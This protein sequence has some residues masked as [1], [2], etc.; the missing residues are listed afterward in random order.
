MIS[1]IDNSSGFCN[2]IAVSWRLIS[3][4][5]WHL[6]LEWVSSSNN[7]S[8]QVSRQVFEEMHQTGAEYDCLE[9][10]PVFR[11]LQ[12]VAADHDY[13]YG[14]ALDD[15]MAISIHS[16]ASSA[17]WKDGWSGA[18]VEETAAPDQ[19]EVQQQKAWSTSISG[20]KNPAAA[21]CRR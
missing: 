19:T 8:D 10:E 2:L 16:S 1:F 12:R 20:Q 7:I 14:Q 5:E 21:S 17:H 13:T 15:L 9:P 11:I 3:R 6:H 18:S 4:L